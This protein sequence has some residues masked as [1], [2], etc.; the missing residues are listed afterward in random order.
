MLTQSGKALVTYSRCSA[1]CSCNSA[2][3]L[4]EL[5]DVTLARAE[6]EVSREIAVR[7]PVSY[8]ALTDLQMAARAREGD[9][10][11]EA[12]S[13]QPA[14]LVPAAAFNASENSL[15][16]PRLLSQAADPLRD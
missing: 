4:L 6:D 3:S 8:K 14:N 12:R 13:E 9:E 10:N 5:R 2:L 1:E 7:V 15:D 11:V 16:D